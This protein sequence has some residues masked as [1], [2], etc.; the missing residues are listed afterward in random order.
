MHY[1][2]RKCN[3]EFDVEIKEHPHPINSFITVGAFG[4]PICR[5]AQL[6]AKTCPNCGS[7]EV[8]QSIVLEEEEK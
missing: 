6:K 3:Y 8:S 7:I 5:N 1:K 2:C 4:C